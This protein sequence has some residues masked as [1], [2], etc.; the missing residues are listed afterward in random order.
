MSI[1]ENIRKL[2]FLTDNLLSSVN[3]YDLEVRLF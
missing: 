2:I 1:H 3:L